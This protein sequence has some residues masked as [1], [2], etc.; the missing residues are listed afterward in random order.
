[1]SGRRNFEKEGRPAL[2]GSEVKPM[3]LEDAWVGTRVLVRSDYRKPH[4]QGAVGTI[5]KRYGTPAYRWPIR[6]SDGPP[7]EGSPGPGR[8]DIGRP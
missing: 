4:R 3:E 5:K 8:G 2:F 7:G 1:M 6:A